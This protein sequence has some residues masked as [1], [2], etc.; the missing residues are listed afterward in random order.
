M[1]SPDEIWLVDFGDPFPGEPAH[2]RPAL[3]C[4]PSRLFGDSL[5]F[6]IVAPMTTT[7]RQFSFQ[8]EI[9]ADGPNGANGL[10]ET[11]YIQCEMLRSINKVR[12]VRRVGL[13][14]VAQARQ[15]NHV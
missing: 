4:G 5:P 10:H 14:T 6:V 15:V 11:S 13:V 12:L 7:Y 3:I 8:V 2:F 9:E 1:A